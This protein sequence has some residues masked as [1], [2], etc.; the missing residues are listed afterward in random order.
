MPSRIASRYKALYLNVST[1]A[2]VSELDKQTSE[3]KAMS[4]LTSH[5]VVLN[6]IQN[7]LFQ[8]MELVS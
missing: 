8:A 1:I 4:W 5:E 2:M 7:K 3:S 6:N